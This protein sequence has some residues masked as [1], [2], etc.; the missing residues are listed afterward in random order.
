MALTI[1][2]S[3]GKQAEDKRKKKDKRKTNCGNGTP[4]HLLLCP[5]LGFDPMGEKEKDGS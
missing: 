3:M 4:D 2:K 1:E 5:N